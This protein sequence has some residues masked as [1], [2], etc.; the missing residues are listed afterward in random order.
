MPADD[1]AMMEA[2]TKSSVAM[3]GDDLREDLE[4]VLEGDFNFKDS[5]AHSSL[6][7]DARNPVLNVTGV[8][9]I[10]LP[11][12]PRDAQLIISSATHAPF[13][14]GTETEV[15]TNLNKARTFYRIRKSYPFDSTVKAQNMFATI[16]VVLPSLYTGGQ[17]HISHS[18]SKQ[19]F[20]FDSNSLLSTAV[21]A[22]YTDVQHEIKPITSGYRLALSYNLIHVTPGLPLPILPSMH[23]SV[24]S[25]R[26]VLKKWR[27]QKYPDEQD[28]MSC[29]T[30]YGVKAPKGQ[31]SYLVA[32]LASCGRT[33][34]F[35]GLANFTLSRNWDSGWYRNDNYEDDDDDEDVPGME[36]VL[37]TTITVNNLVDMEISFVQKLVESGP[38]KDRQ[39][40]QGWSAQLVSQ[41]LITV[42]APTVQDVPLFIKTTKKQ[43]LSYVTKT[44][45]ILQK[46]A[47]PRYADVLKALEG[48]QEF[49]LPWNSATPSAS[50]S[51]NHSP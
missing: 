19:I 18:S 31:D 23:S 1:S 25:L 10:G 24:T 22:W 2:A 28:M 17:V 37:D 44:G 43:G 15:D 29:G 34:L 47:G 42:E 5:Y 12:S 7:S 36:E 35:V 6:F 16:I 8:G 21:M 20:S 46:V 30:V 14:H 41:L 27:A 48:K 49:V 26:R 11:L 33:R 3:N 32:P 50:A 39:L 4:K 40:A 45:S 9:L 38:L 51:S 13:G